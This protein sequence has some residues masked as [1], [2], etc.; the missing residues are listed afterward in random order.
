MQEDSTFD[1]M[2]G[3]AV[4]GALTAGLGYRSLR[5][6]TGRRTK[7]VKGA[8][9]ELV[10]NPLAKAGAQKPTIP[11]SDQLKLAAALKT[12]RSRKGEKALRDALG[13]GAGVASR[14]RLPRFR[15]FTPTEQFSPE[16]IKALA[17]HTKML[18]TGSPS[19]TRTLTYAGLGAGVGGALGLSPS[20]DSGYDEYEDPLRVGEDADLTAG[21]TL[22][23]KH[24]A[25]G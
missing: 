8:V 13:D 6:L 17:K 7:A 19:L 22:P 12:L 2:L 9:D 25:H 4:I 23:G 21:M 1:D 15:G 3:T 24:W 14:P 16:Q 18:E 10:K 11:D 5:N 20:T